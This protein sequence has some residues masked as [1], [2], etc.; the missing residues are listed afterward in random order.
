MQEEQDKNL[1]LTGIIRIF[2]MTA[3]SCLVLGLPS[4]HNAE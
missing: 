1:N 3:L 4:T 2:R